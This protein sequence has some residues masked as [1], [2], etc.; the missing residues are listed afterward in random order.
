M[1]QPEAFIEISGF[2]WS[3]LIGCIAIGIV[4]WFRPKFYKPENMTDEQ[5]VKYERTSRLTAVG[6][7]ASGIAFAA[8]Y[9]AY[10]HHI[11]WLV[12]AAAA[13]WAVVM[14][15]LWRADRAKM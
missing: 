8:G 13:V 6:T 2:A 4:S 1:N 11:T 15:L 12:V 7:W 9:T 5:L 10:Q 3:I 14:L